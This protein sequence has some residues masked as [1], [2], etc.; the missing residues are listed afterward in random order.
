MAKYTVELN[1]IEKSGLKIFNFNYDFYNPTLK[2]DFE[3]KF[4]NHFRF[5]EIGVE[6]VGRFQHNLKVKCDE[7]LPYYNMLLET[8][9]YEYDLKNNYNLTETFTKTNNKTN[10]LTGTTTTDGET[11]NNKTANLNSNS[12]HTQTT[13]FAK[14]ETIDET[15]T[16]NGLTTIES[17][18]KIVDSDTPTALLSMVDIETN[19]YATKAN[20]ADGTNT[21]TEAQTNVTNHTGNQTENTDITANDTV[22]A[23]NTE[24][25]TGTL[26]NVVDTVQ[27]AT[28]I[29]N[30]S[31]T[32]ERVGDIGVDTTPDKIKKHIEIQ[33]IL[34]T[35][36]LQFF[37]ECDDLFM[38]IF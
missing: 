36:Y 29:N 9:L 38:Q 16:N 34:K 32:L 10:D 1:D 30:E 4:I 8:S 3:E 5:R 7:V 31:Y 14:D 2:P 13:D 26:N 17:K 11:G 12:D 25:A 21:N 24:T 22:V 33:K 37:N 19:V 35:I 23:T 18:N 15:G 6:T 28:E 27:N 20:I